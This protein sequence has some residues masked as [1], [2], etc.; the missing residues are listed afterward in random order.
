MPRASI[1][2]S[3]GTSSAFQVLL[4]GVEETHLTVPSTRPIEVNSWSDGSLFLQG[5]S[6][7]I[8]ADDSMLWNAG[9]TIRNTPSVL[10]I[11]PDTDSTF[12]EAGISADGPFIDLP[13]GRKVSVNV[14]SVA[15]NF[16]F[17]VNLA[18]VDLSPELLAKPWN[19]LFV[20]ANPATV[21]F[22]AAAGDATNYDYELTPDIMQISDPANS[23]VIPLI[24]IDG[25]NIASGAGND[26][27]EID[28]ATAQPTDFDF[29]GGGGVNSLTVD[30]S[31]TT[32]S[33]N[34]TIHPKEVNVTGQF[35]ADL[36][37]FD[38]FK[39]LGGSGDDTFALGGNFTQPVSVDGGAGNDSFAIGNHIFGGVSFA[40]R[41]S[42][43]AATETT[44][45][46][47]TTPLTPLH[48]SRPG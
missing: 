48:S 40:A 20:N 46:R 25:V 41:R 45:S 47:F 38:Q 36:A 3:D 22:Q 7:G 35:D 26:R 32:S 34:W 11:D 29:D 43:P 17:I 14:D 9:I 2:W 12:S 15:T 27:F 18:L 44:P 5:G 37:N 33:A 42:S 10:L 28:G 6:V 1:Y 39:F 30:D 4:G 8:T 23:M 21:Q 13:D 19:I 16:S 24:G 31:Q